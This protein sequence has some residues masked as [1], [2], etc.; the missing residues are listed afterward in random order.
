MEEAST[1]AI[2][3]TSA[4][5]DFVAAA[6]LPTCKLSKPIPVYNMDETPNEAESIC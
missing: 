2:V 1:E 6:K 5:G 3:D 4:T